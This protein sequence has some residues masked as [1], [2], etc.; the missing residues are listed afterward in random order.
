M[1][2]G[3]PTSKWVAV[4]TSLATFLMDPANAGTGAGIGYFPFVAGGMQ[5]TCTMAQNGM[6]GCICILGICIDTSAL[7]NIGGSC[8]VADYSK[9]DVPIAQLLPVGAMIQAS[10]QSHAP[11]GGTPT[12]PALQGAYQYTSAWAKA[13]PGRRTVLV[14]ATDGEPTGCDQTNQVPN[15]ATDLV[16]PALAAT[17]SISTFVIGVGSSLTSLNQLAMAGG[18]KQ[19][20]IVDT[21]GDV[22]KQFAMALDAI[23]GQAASCEFAIPNDGTVDSSKVNATYTPP[24]GT[25]SDVL[26]VA[27]QSKC[28]AT[29]AY[30]YFSPD[31]RQLV[32]CPNMC[33]TLT[34]KSGSVQVV[35]GC[36]TKKPIIQ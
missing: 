1:A 33:D 27:D 15:I 29:D 32:L 11:G 14:L 21:G 19:A 5:S 17:P 16:A 24:G 9:P 7:G 34:Q 22:A 6:N 25:A 31:K 2:Q 28:T 23:R 10:L 20:F 4:T 8:T 13:N 26:G 36:P 30:W 3:N 35:L 12:Y 18:T